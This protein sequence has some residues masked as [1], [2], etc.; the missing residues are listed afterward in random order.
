MERGRRK[1]RR[2]EE[3]RGYK[4]GGKEPEKRYLQPRIPATYG[5]FNLEWENLEFWEEDGKIKNEGARGK[6]RGVAVHQNPSWLEGEPP[7][8]GKPRNLEYKVDNARFP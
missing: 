1:R 8:L 2:E 4:R 5:E 6:G 7:F 3:Y